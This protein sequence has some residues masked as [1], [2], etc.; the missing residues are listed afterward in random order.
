MLS[1]ELKLSIQ[2]ADA[3]IGYA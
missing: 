3:Y 1:E 2:G